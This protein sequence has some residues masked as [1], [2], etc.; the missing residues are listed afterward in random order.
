MVS[1]AVEKKFLEY[2]GNFYDFGAGAVYASKDGKGN[3]VIT[4]AVSSALFNSNNFY[5]GRWRSVWTATFTPGKQAALV[6]CRL[7][8]G[9]AIL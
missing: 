9:S 6:V 1:S 5:N 7:N 2:V 4:A 3:V 8:C